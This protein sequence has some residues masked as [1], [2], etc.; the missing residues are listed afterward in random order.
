M[1]DLDPGGRYGCKGTIKTMLKRRRDSVQI[2]P[3]T[4]MKICSVV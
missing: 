3:N 4:D 2:L 1:N